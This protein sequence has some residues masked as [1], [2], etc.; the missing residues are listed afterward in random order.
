MISLESKS[1]RY[2]HPCIHIHYQ[3]QTE[4]SFLEYHQ[5]KPL[6]QGNTYLNYSTNNDKVM[7]LTVV[8]RI[9]KIS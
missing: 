5:I 6:V 3:T 4:D 8:L 2:Q 7:G 1:A 9:Y